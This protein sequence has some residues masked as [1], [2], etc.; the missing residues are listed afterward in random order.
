ME[1][2][3]KDYLDQL[4]GALR[5][6]E[7][8]VRFAR[9]KDALS[10]SFFNDSFDRMQHISRLLHQLQSMQIDEMKHQMEHLVALLSEQTEKDTPPATTQKEGASVNEVAVAVGEQSAAGE[11]ATKAVPVS[12]TDGRHAGAVVLPGYKN[13]RMT[14]PMPSEQPQ[15]VH[16]AT[17]RD[18]KQGMHALNDVIQAPPSLLDLKRGISLNDKFIFQRELFNNDRH[19]MNSVMIR[20]NAF[21]TYEHAESYLK[22]SKEWNF[23]DPIVQDFLRV[24]KKGF[25]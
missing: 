8:E 21:D 14:T 23:D 15:S 17:D 25:A 1:N 12:D 24:I 16:N 4:L 7:E 22:E 9:E 3:R 6:L 11:S 19:E 13:P 2:K 20:L 10:F 5:Q 18:E